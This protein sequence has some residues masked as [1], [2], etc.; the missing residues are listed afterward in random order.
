MKL[1]ILLVCLIVLSPNDV[2]T[3]TKVNNGAVLENPS[4]LGIKGHFGFVVTELRP[5][6]SSTQL[7]VGDVLI[8]TDVTNQVANIEEFQTTIRGLEPESSIR[9][10]LVRFQGESKSFVEHEAKLKVTKQPNS[11][12]STLGIGGKMGFLVKEIDPSITQPNIEIGDIITDLELGGQI[13]DISAFQNLVRSVT[14][15]QEIRAIKWRFESDSPSSQDTILR[16]HPY[17]QQKKTVSFA[18]VSDCPFGNCSWCCDSCPDTGQGNKMCKKS[19]C[20]TLITRCRL[21]PWRTCTYD[22]C[23]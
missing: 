21:T 16:T 11:L 1:T 12:T 5:V 15:G 4:R 9:V 13:Q 18:G 17:P 7:R 6:D 19:L 20:E 14:R 22:Y 23:V 8:S 3:Q 2:F 10:L